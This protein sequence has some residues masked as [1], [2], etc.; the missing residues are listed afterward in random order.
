MRIPCPPFDLP[1]PHAAGWMAALLAGLFLLPPVDAQAQEVPPEPLLY[2]AD[3][4][5]IWRVVPGADD[6]VILQVDEPVVLKGIAVDAVSERLVW[7]E[8]DYRSQEYGS[9]RRSYLDGS[10]VE[11]IDN[12]AQ[13]GIGDFGGVLLDGDW[14]FWGVWSDCVGVELGR[15]RQDGSARAWINTWGWRMRGVDAHAAAGH[16]YWT[17]LGYLGSGPVVRRSALD[18]SEAENLIGLDGPPWGLALDRENGHI[19]WGEAG[20]PARLMRADL[21]GTNVQEILT[22][23]EWIGATHVD[24]PGG[25]V[26]WTRPDRMIRR[27]R[28]DGSAIEDFYLLPD[29]FSGWALFRPAGSSIDPPAPLTGALLEQSYPNPALGTATIR[30][31]LAYAASA[32]LEVF[33]LL[34]RHVA[35]LADGSHAPGE[36]TVVFDVGRLAAGTY[37]YR[38]TARDAVLERRLIVPGR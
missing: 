5:R 26:Y 9:I 32:R 21:D 34:G 2:V 6:H 17:S 7:L 16:L 25:Y 35:T 15:V 3:E 8:E 11:T 36:H 33:D 12:H 31:T 38:L 37:V 28:L 22:S 23:S 4:Q 27:A 13:C 29:G 30:Y 1:K 20:E 10:Q 19:Y 14:V 18:G 24:V